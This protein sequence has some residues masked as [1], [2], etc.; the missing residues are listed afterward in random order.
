VSVS[1]PWRFWIAQ[2]LDGAIEFPIVTSSPWIRRW[3]RRDS[4]SP[5]GGQHGPVRRPQDVTMDLA[6]EHRHLMA[7]YDH[8][9][10]GVGHLATGEPDQLEHATE[11][12]V[13]ERE[14]HRRMLTESGD[15]SQS[16]AHSPWTAFWTHPQ[17]P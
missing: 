6:L 17:V 3:P 4:L 8:L 5:S 11:C 14:S 16:P 12:P 1:M 15:G 10:R 13:Q 7:K 2:W 9:N